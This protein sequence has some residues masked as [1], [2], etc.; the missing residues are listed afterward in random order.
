MQYLS[1]S[2]RLWWLSNGSVI[3][4]WGVK[5]ALFCASKWVLRLY[6]CDKAATTSTNKTVV[7]GRKIRTVGTWWWMHSWITESSNTTFGKPYSSA[8]NISEV[9]QFFVYY[10]QLNNN[11]TM[12][13]IL[14]M[15]IGGSLVFFGKKFFLNKLV[16]NL[17]RF[18]SKRVF[19]RCFLG[20]WNIN[21]LDSHSLKETTTC[22]SPKV[23]VLGPISIIGY[24][25]ASYQC[26]SV[27]LIGKFDGPLLFNTR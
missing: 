4:Q 13:S 12:L 10:L 1:E 20:Q 3:R 18:G 11:N 2:A 6:S 7:S 17:F 15:A 27:W 26:Q 5:L 23:R 25:T 22:K 21:T 19:L 16:Q 14:L 9:S 24:Y 8:N